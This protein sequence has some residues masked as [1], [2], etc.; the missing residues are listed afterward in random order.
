MLLSDFEE[1][2]SLV[3]HH[4]LALTGLA[5]VMLAGCQTPTKSL[6]PV[7]QPAV[8]TKTDIWMRVA[9]LDDIERIRT[10]DGAWTAAL[11]EAPRKSVAAEGALLRPGAALARPAPTPGAYECRLV[12]LEREKPKSPAFERFKPFF[13]Y[14]QL[15]GETLTLVKQTGSERPVGRLWDDGASTR[16]VFLGSMTKGAE[17]ESLPYGLDRSRDMAGVFERIAPFRWRL[18]IPWPRSKAKLEV[19]EL[20]PIVEPNPGED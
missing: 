8:P 11:A 6:P 13:C 14:V 10:L 1:M 4:C 18:V 19:F 20:T 9:N 2:E 7:A 17:S 16:M 3:R 12:R 5:A 15:D